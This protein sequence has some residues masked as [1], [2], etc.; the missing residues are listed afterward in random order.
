[1]S[2]GEI[3]CLSKIQWPLFRYTVILK[4]LLVWA[5]ININH[6]G[7]RR[8][9]SYRESRREEGYFLVSGFLCSKWKIDLLLWNQ[10]KRGRV[11]KVANLRLDS[12]AR[13]YEWATEDLVECFWWC[14]IFFNCFS[15]NRNWG[16]SKRNV[17]VLKL[18]TEWDK[19]PRN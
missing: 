4:R 7:K 5:P 18:N 10:Q 14:F 2:K 3:T 1:M 19:K 17:C 15:K 11:M 8:R 13:K 16:W 9:G 6:W 12:R